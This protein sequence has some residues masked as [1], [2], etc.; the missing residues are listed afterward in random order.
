[1]TDLDALV[2]DYNKEQKREVIIR[3]KDLKE[4]KLPRITSGSL[5]FDVILGGGWPLN[6]WNELVGQPS[7]GKSVV[8]MKSIAAQQAADPDHE[9][10]WIAAEEFVPD[11]AQTCGVD[12]D[13][14]AVAEVNEAEAA[15][16]LVVD[17]LEKRAMDAVVIDSLPALT[18]TGE[19][20][21]NVGEW[22][23]GL[24]ARLMGQF[25]RKSGQTQRRSLTEPD[26][27]C[28]CLAVNQWRYKIGL[29][30]K[31]DPR[32]TPGGVGKDFSYF[33]RAEV[34]RDEWLVDSKKR[35][36]GQTI[37]MRTIKN[38]SAP[39]QQRCAFDF[40]FAPGGAVD[41]GQ[42]DTIG[43]LL[44][45]ALVFDVVQQGGGWYTFNEERIG[46][47]GRDTVVNYLRGDLTMQEQIRSEVMK[48]AL[49]SA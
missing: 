8:A 33:V 30:P 46:E 47:R 37:M 18:P 32:T 38:K 2:R 6:V 35:R 7:A 21:N 23:P 40:Y 39:P 15:F 48:V 41:P 19:Y 28:F 25:M 22:L 27:P 11:W 17:A 44:N 12:I 5:T 3:G 42:Y 14:I 34:A 24:Q 49:H 31:M 43:E 29:N 45:T 26:R 1:L 36:I 20:E 9:T 4:R 10:L 13:R 16:Q